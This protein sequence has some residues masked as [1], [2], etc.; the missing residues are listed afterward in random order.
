M[1]RKKKIFRLRDCAKT[2]GTVQ[3]V[4]KKKST[5]LKGG[6]EGEKRNLGSF[7]Y[8]PPAKDSSRLREEY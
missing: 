3:K 7:S 1:R 5:P 8:L 4:K 6:I 2:T